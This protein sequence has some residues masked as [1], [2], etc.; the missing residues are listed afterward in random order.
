MHGFRFRVQGLGRVKALVATWTP[1]VC[2]IMAFMAVIL[3]LRQ[4][5]YIL[6]LACI[7]WVAV[8]ERKLSY[9]NGYIHIYRVNNRVSPIQ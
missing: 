9:H 7:N 1:K 4:L 8:K 3:D 5:F 6:G 2:K